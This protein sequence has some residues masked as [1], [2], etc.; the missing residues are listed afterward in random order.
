M[1]GRILIVADDEP[2]RSVFARALRAQDIEI[3]ELT[4]GEAAIG[5]I[6]SGNYDVV[7][8]DLHLP[9]RDGFA[10]LAAIRSDNHRPIVL[11]LSASSEDVRRVAGERAVMMCIN[12]TFA[13][14]NLDPVIAAIAA[15]T[16]LQQ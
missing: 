3:D 8:L 13:V 16:R 4:D 5:A 9:K 10:V 15:V 6:R 14:R 2:V 12:K 1:P 11:V 7:V